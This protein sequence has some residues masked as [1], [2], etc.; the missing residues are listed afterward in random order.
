MVNA[1]DAIFEQ[2]PKAVNAASVGVAVYVDPL[3]VVDSPVNVPMLRKIVV[4]KG[5]IEDAPPIV[6]G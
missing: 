4:G 1:T 6:E 2:P 5:F 3:G